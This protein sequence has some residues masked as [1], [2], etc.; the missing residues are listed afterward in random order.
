MECGTIVAQPSPFITFGERTREAEW[1]WHAALYRAKGAETKYICGGSLISQHHVLTVAHCVARVYSN[2][3]ISLDS[4]VIYLGKYFLTKY[5][6]GIQYFQV[7]TFLTT[8]AHRF[9]S[10]FSF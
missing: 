6:P 5:N 10:K 4:L 7:S 8:A 3:A 9:S 1:P 2:S